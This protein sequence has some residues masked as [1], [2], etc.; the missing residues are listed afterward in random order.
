M[1]KFDQK[2]AHDFI[3]NFWQKLKIDFERLKIIKQTYSQNLGI[4]VVDKEILRRI[5]NSN[6]CAASNDER[7]PAS[8]SEAQVAWSTTGA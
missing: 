8:A 2:V 1:I 5:F 7:P 6:H 4:Y 3:M